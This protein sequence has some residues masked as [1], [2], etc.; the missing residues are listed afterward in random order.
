MRPKNG[1]HSDSD[2]DCSED[3]EEDLDTMEPYQ[4]VKK[5]TN[6]RWK[7]NWRQPTRVPTKKWVTETKKGQRMTLMDYEDVRDILRTL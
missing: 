2:S 5:S 7:T 3:D 6:Q 4:Q 1:H